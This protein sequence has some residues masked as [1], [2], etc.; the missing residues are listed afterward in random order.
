MVP[1]LEMEDKGVKVGG[2]THSSQANITCAL[3]SRLHQGVKKWLPEYKDIW[4]H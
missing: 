4:G 3:N 1:L 2:S